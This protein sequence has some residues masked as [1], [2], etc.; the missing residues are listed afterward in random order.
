M[1]TTSR[2]LKNSERSRA[3]SAKEFCKVEYSADADADADVDAD[4][5]ADADAESIH[6]TRSPL[7]SYSGQGSSKR[8]VCN[9]CPTIDGKP[10]EP[11]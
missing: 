7:F 8:R 10:V 1:G 6:L 5:D 4:A 2:S 3:I 11:F 9:G